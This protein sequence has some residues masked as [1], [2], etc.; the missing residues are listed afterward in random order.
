MNS[1]LTIEFIEDKHWLGGSIYIENLLSALSMLPSSAR[2][3]IRLRF[4]SSQ[5]TPLAKRLTRHSAIS[6]GR[7][8]WRGDIL[9]TARRIH[10][11]LT[12][13][14]PWLGRFTA[15]S[16]NDL[17]FPVFDAKQSWRK[18]L[19]WIP[20]FQPHYLPELFDAV[21]LSSRM[22]SFR[23]IAD[24]RGILLLSSNT[25]LAD[26]R[27]FYPD[28]TVESRVWSFYSNIEP[29]LASACAEVV[30]KYGLP[31]KFLYI[32][33]QF[34]RHKD[35]A[36]AF[37]ALRI[38]RERGLD[39]QIVCTGFQND[40]RDAAYFD[41]LKH[42]LENFGLQDQV[43]F[44]GVIPREDQIQVFRATAAV[45]QPSRFEGWSTVIEDAKAL[46]RPIIASDIPVHKEQ[47]AGVV[48]AHLFK[49]SDA[50]DLAQIIS[51]VWPNLTEGPDLQV[52]KKAIEQGNEWRLASAKRFVA[53][54][55]EALVYPPD[56]NNKKR[57]QQ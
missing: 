21:E 11:G 19:Y 51:S 47:L 30:R 23:D 49:V 38:L 2:P 3:R 31:K 26:F 6:V 29:G 18:N 13:R 22:Q 28:A 33:N 5:H 17:Y 12:R 56:G 57:E 10:R 52:E 42:M 27:R 50:G 41:S 20:D 8:N 1:G 37:E 55:E 34:W 54:V 53:I 35:H 4:F 32:A 24:T 46:G 43:R 9:S 25:A 39:I 45:L 36:T 15:S 44:L 14:A 40:R 7:P 16:N 48:C